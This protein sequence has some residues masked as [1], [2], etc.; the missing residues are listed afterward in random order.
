ML[1]CLQ[2]GG[3]VAAQLIAREGFIGGSVKT[4]NGDELEGVSLTLSPMADSEVRSAISDS[5]GTFQ[6]PDLPDGDYTLTVHSPGYVATT[7]QVVLSPGQHVT[8]SVRLA[9]SEYAFAIEAGHPLEVK[10][11]NGPQETSASGKSVLPEDPVPAIAEDAGGGEDVQ[12]AW[13]GLGAIG[14]FRQVGN[15]A[16]SFML[17]GVSAAPVLHGEMYGMLGRAFLPSAQTPGNS[18]LTPEQQYGASAGAEIGRSS[19][20]AS[21]DRHVLDRRQL[22]REML[23]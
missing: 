14:Q 13:T 1:Y 16:R 3:P 19:L 10:L 7:K 5:L 12:A 4:I 22:L 11:L 6:F 2:R 21:Y 23:C 18:Q 9:P 15:Y 8:I 20:F 17:A